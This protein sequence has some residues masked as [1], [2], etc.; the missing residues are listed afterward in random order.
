MSGPSVLYAS[1]LCVNCGP[2]STIAS[3]LIAG[4]F[5]VSNSG[6]YSFNGDESKA[7]SISSVNDTAT[8]NVAPN[9][10]V[11]AQGGARPPLFYLVSPGRAF[12]ML[13]DG[14][15]YAGFA[16]PQTGGPFTNH[17]ANGTYVFGS[18]GVTHQNITHESGLATYDGMGTVVGTSDTALVGSTSSSLSLKPDQTFS[19]TYAVSPNGKLMLTQ[20]PTIYIISPTKQVVL[21]VDPSDLYARIEPVEQ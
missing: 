16:E 11:M 1:G 2:G 6:N 12:V 17:S 4:I 18:T 7:G 10:R 21:N 5:T 8:V 20:G 13:V 9:G 15:V 14:G 19:Y 3:D